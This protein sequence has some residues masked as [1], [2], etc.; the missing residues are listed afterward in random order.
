MLGE[1][2]SSPGLLQRVLQ[3]MR[4]MRWYPGTVDAVLRYIWT[5]ELSAGNVAPTDRPVVYVEPGWLRVTESPYSAHPY[6]VT[7]YSLITNVDEHRI[8]LPGGLSLKWASIR[9]STVPEQD[10]QSMRLELRSP[11][12]GGEP[13][14]VVVFEVRN[15]ELGQVVHGPTEV[16]FT[17]SDSRPF[18]DNLREF[19]RFVVGQH[20]LLI[21]P[22][23]HQAMAGRPS[24]ADAGRLTLVPA[25]PI[26]GWMGLGGSRA[27]A[28]PG[29]LIGARST[30][31]P[32]D[33][34][35]SYS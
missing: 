33:Q 15:W 25:L 18:W 11:P 10:R 2:P 23:E 24:S 22:P 19:A 4:A 1:Q 30:S 16:D 29:I 20:E 3:S 9:A 17:F 12:G 21:S 32:T 13:E 27:G 14:P 26:P 5:G 31:L 28:Q 8:P 34:S 6:S 35:R 7:L